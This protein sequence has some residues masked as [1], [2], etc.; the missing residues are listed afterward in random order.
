MPSSTIIPRTLTAN[1]LNWQTVDGSLKY[2]QARLNK[3]VNSKKA[4]RA[5]ISR[6]C[7]YLKK[8]ENGGSKLHRKMRRISLTIK[9]LKLP[10]VIG[11]P[12]RPTQWSNIPIESPT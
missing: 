4:F 11:I 5:E 6:C 7:H 10:F 1:S 12:Y 8:P 3:A 2:L 9:A